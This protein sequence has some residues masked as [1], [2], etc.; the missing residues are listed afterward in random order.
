MYVYL[1]MNKKICTCGGKK[2]S[3]ALQCRKCKDKE[4]ESK[5]CKGCNKVYP[6]TA[7][8]LRLKR[9]NTKRRSRCSKCEVIACLKYQAKTPETVRAAKR[10]YVLDNPHK[11]SYWA[12]RSQFIRV[13]LDPDVGTALYQQHNKQ[14]DICGKTET[15]NKQRLCIDHCHTEVKFRGFLC[16]TCNHGLGNFKDNIEVMRAAIKYLQKATRK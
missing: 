9:G 8:A 15:E 11:S 10:Q 3:R 14:C 5:L 7:F 2:D 13:N 12:M 4:P 1:R 6:I 16:S